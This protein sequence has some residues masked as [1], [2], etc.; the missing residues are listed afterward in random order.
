MS[1]IKRTSCAMFYSLEYRISR[2]GFNGL[3]CLFAVIS[4]IDKSL[5]GNTG[6][7]QTEGL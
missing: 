7:R 3:K 4:V 6:A 1:S 2:L 5:P